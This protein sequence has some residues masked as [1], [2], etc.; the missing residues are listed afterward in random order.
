MCQ[1]LGAED[2]VMN[3]TE[4]LSLGVLQMIEGQL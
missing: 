1:T 3:K 2:T 4:S